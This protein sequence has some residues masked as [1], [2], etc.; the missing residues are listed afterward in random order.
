NTGGASSPYQFNTAG[1]TYGPSADTGSNP[2]YYPCVTTECVLY[3]AGRNPSNPINQAQDQQQLNTL[4]AVGLV[5]GAP[6]AGG[7]GLPVLV[8]AGV[9][10][11]TVSL[12]GGVAGVTGGQWL[13]SAGG[14]ALIGVAGEGLLHPST[15]TPGSVFW[16]GLGG[17][18]GGATKLVGNAYCGLANQW[19]RSTWRNVGTALLGSQLVG[20][21]VNQGGSAVTNVNGGTSWWNSPIFGRSNPQ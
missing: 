17:S 13:A 12:T 5:V 16:A 4:G 7:L 3:G 9:T 21:S 14:G 11:Q 1:M 10:A 20:R 6:L 8:N 18:L 15:A 2:R 19:V